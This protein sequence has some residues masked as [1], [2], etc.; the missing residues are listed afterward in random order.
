[1]KYLFLYLLGVLTGM[2]IIALCVVNSKK[3]D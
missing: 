3:E 2:V 1:M